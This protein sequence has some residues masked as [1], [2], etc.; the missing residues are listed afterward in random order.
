M[1]LGVDAAELRPPGSFEEPGR[2]DAVCFETK[3]PLQKSLKNA[4]DLGGPNRRWAEI[5]LV[6][7]NAVRDEKSGP[8]GKGAM[9]LGRWK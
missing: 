5:V 4:E 1:L 7:F 2:A 6:C 9:L 3:T 8:I